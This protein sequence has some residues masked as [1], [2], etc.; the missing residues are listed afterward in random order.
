MSNSH[1]YSFACN[2]QPSEM[3]QLSG[4]L[5]RGH[6]DSVAAHFGET[7]VHIDRRTL[8]RLGVS[9]ALLPTLGSVIAADTAPEALFLLLGDIGPTMDAAQLQAVMDPFVQAEIRLGIIVDGPDG[10]APM[11]MYSASLRHLLGQRPDLLELVLAVPNLANATPYFQ[12]RRTSDALTAVVQAYGLGGVAEGNGGV[13]SLPVTLATEVAAAAQYNSLR[14]LGIRTVIDLQTLPQVTT[15][16]CADR[17]ICVQGARTVLLA[18]TDP[19]ANML[20][21]ISP[22]GWAQ[23]VL[24]LAASERLPPADLRMRSEVLVAAINKEVHAG[25]RFAA[26]PRDQVRWFGDDQP[27]RL[28]LRI[29]SPPSGDADAATG[30]HLLLL[31]LNEAGIPFTLSTSPDA[32][33][34][35]ATTCLTLDALTD[36]DALVWLAQRDQPGTACAS[37]SVSSG[38]SPQLA[39]ALDLLLIPD[40]HPAFDDRGLLRLTEVPIEEGST[41]AF[42][43]GAIRDAVLAVSA[44]FYTSAEGR[45]AALNL[46]GQMKAT[47][48]T[49]ISDVP[50]FVAAVVSTDPVFRILQLTRRSALGQEQ[51]QPEITRSE[52]LAD[53]RQAWT[54]FERFSDPVTGLCADTVQVVEGA[55]YLHAELTM[56]DIGS[57]VQAVLASHELGFVDDEEFVQRIGLLLDVVTGR[58]TGDLIL[59]SAV[60]ATATGASLSPDFNACDVGR[61]LATLKELDAHP[62]VTG[63]AAKVVAGWTLS[64][65]IADGYLRSVV[66]GQLRKRP[67]SHCEHYTARSLRTWGFKAASPYDAI[68]ATSRTDR[69]M[70]ILGKVANI[71]PFGAEPLLL[72]G[73]EM[74]L[75]EPSSLLADVL[76]DQQ[77]RAHAATGQFF[78]VSEA[79]LNREPWFTYQ[80]L[81][82][83]TPDQPWVVAAT[84]PD[85]QYQTKAFQTDAMLVS[86]KAAYLWAAVRPS[87]YSTRLVQHVRTRARLDGMGFSP[88]VFTATGE[89]MLSYAD[90]NTNG[91]VL[92]AIA[93]MLRGHKPRSM[94]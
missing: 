93:Y 10:N 36:T 78:C 73:M 26:L 64:A 46:L 23:I 70:Q 58:T 80:G 94:S 1:C 56:W 90:V 4:A 32:P 62:L 11:P 38:V 68:D 69:Q 55:T 91:I 14:A 67:I 34:T 2:K 22:A 3:T 52:L 12:R 65:A 54:F 29:D 87:A 79:P 18:D 92:E 86:T 5:R 6:F 88:G 50:D 89:G 77:R 44:K 8:L 33:E 13:L 59:P 72:E 9:T 66:D 35:L 48:A 47:E 21:A 63:A 51:N 28:A 24:S 76:L 16:G 60:I 42:D 49:T 81:S 27:R 43:P 31:A 15:S 19:A 25:N 30:F 41:L 53:A 7:R 57:L 74:G 17:M 39:A 75:S 40:G 71:G 84:W 37:R 45:S 85:A 61:L 82:I 20:H 83:D